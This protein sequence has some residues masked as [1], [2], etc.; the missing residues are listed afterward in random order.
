MSIQKHTCAC[1]PSARAVC[2]DYQTQSLRQS[3]V[4]IV[5]DVR[6]QGKVH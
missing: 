4:Q 1:L 3:M 6:N 5:T 2:S